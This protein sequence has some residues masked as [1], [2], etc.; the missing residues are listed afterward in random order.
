MSLLTV[1][2]HFDALETEA[3]LPDEQYKAL[4]IGDKILVQLDGDEPEAK[5]FRVSG[6]ARY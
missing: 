5:T 6:C 3:G 4:K 1:V 2:K